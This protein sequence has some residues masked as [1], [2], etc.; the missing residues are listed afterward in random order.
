VE[1]VSEEQSIEEYQDIITQKPTLYRSINQNEYFIFDMNIPFF[2]EV[3]NC[4]DRTTTSI[5]NRWISMK[6]AKLRKKVNKKVR[7]KISKST[8]FNLNEL[9]QVNILSSLENIKFDSNYHKIIDALHGKPMEGSVVQ[10]IL[11]K[12][13]SKNH[14]LSYE[15]LQE[16][17]TILE[18]A[19]YIK[20]TWTLVR[21]KNYSRI[22]ELVRLHPLTIKEI[23]DAYNE[24]QSKKNQKSE[25]TIYRYI[26]T[27]I[28]ANLIMQSGQRLT[29]G[30]TATETLF[31]ISA[32]FFFSPKDS[33]FWETS[34][35]E[36]ISLL[37]QKIFFAS[38]NRINPSKKCIQELFTNFAKII[39]NEKINLLKNI[40]ETFFNEVS[41]SSID[42]LNTAFN[43]AGLL[44]LYQKNPHAI[45]ELWECLDK[46]SD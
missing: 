31:G 37:I 21:D 8:E 17:V 46:E 33:S 13:I 36:T 22:I 38:S 26:K 19:D 34:W 7:E 3:M 40:N 20:K 2:F 15:K 32:L 27:L 42:D 44:L 43:Y 35:G 29:Y 11:N 5:A 10:A 45:K 18:D 39:D 25:N 9:V 4:G 14:Q 1:S 6:E 30:K 23:K 28:S 24:G 16:Y 12:E 41:G